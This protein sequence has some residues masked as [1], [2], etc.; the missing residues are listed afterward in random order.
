MSLFLATLGLGLGGLLLMALPGM[1][2]HARAGHTRVHARARGHTR[3]SAR[4][5]VRGRG[6]GQAKAGA[7]GA[8]AHATHAPQQVARHGVADSLLR[9]VPE[10]HLIFS[11]LA[12]FGAFG[13]VLQRT[14]HLPFWTAALAAGGIAVTLE[15]L[16]VARLWRFALRF[17]GAPTSSLGSLLM[18]QVEAVTAFRNGKGIVRAVLDGRAVQ[19]SAELIPEESALTV[20]V[21]DALTIQEVDPERERVRVS[22]R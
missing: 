15:W 7:H 12:L 10:P 20:R 1:R 5:N 6:A 21:G 8:H 19:L 4:A 16:V 18:D 3:A 11:V 14:L 9:F 13:N 17:T 2:R 22:V